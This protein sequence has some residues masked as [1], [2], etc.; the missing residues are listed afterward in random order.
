VIPPFRPKLRR[1]LLALLAVSVL[2]TS[3]LTVVPQAAAAGP[4]TPAGDDLIAGC[5]GGSV[6]ADL[7]GSGDTAVVSGRATVC[8]STGDTRGRGGAARPYWTYE[9]VCSTDRSRAAEGL[10]SATP[11]DGGSHFAFRTL[12]Q[13]D[14]RTE[15]AGSSCVRLDSAAAAP[16]LT[17]AD[18]FAAVRAVQ[19]PS[20]AIHAAPSGRGLAN[21]PAYLWLVGDELAPVNLRLAGST[22]HAEFRPVAYRWSLGSAADGRVV[23]AS[24]DPRDRH[25]ATGA[26]FASGGDFTVS[27]VTEWSATASLDG[28]FVGQV[29]GLASTARI[30][31][32]VVELRT[33]LNG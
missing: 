30:S 18:V 16:G 26:V 10:C 24:A 28:R 22:I 23:A 25:G 8:R 11:C 27:V 19:L 3:M 31:Y 7:D 32:P 12:H 2:A 17:A 33:A 9:I 4:G 21:L 6:E 29:D 1:R 20:G 5:R 14:G 13:P 15:P